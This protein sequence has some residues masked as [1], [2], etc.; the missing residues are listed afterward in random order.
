MT[1][2]RNYVKRVSSYWEGRKTVP[3]KISRSELC[4]IL[5]AINAVEV[6]RCRDCKY[7]MF[8]DFY[9]ECGKVH[10]GVVGPDDFCSRGEQKDGDGDG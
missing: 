2:T 4:D 1:T 8:S 3:V 5:V 9:G 10:M 7:L 6:V